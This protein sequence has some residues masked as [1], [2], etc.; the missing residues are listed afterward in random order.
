LD[1]NGNPRWVAQDVCEAL[2]I[3]NTSLVVNGRKDRPGS[4]L[5]DDEKGVAIVNT[6]G[7]E[8]SLTTVNEAGLYKLIL[9][10]RKPQAK[11]FQRWI[12]HEVIPAI[13]R[14]GSYSVRQGIEPM[15]EMSRLVTATLE[16]QVETEK[17][18]A[19]LEMR[20]EGMEAKRT[21]LGPVNPITADAMVNQRV[22]DWVE[23]HRDNP[24]VS[25]S[26]VWNQIYYQFKYR[27]RRDLRLIAATRGISGVQAAV[28]IGC[29][30]ELLTLT[31]YLT[32]CDFE[33]YFN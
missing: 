5:D 30:N 19:K 29:I 20:I 1:E 3:D 31:V 26:N 2:G 10:S 16:R 33:G 14:T 32:D 11:A 21:L 12:T 6:P 9:K 23:K 17:R 28:A 27:Y 22:R 7:G 24:A 15:L 13:R 25:Y 8:Q 4:G 18:L